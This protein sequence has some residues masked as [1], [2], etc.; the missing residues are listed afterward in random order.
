MIVISWPCLLPLQAVWPGS[1]GA[2]QAFRTGRAYRGLHELFRPVKCLVVLHRGDFWSGKSYQMFTEAASTMVVR[3]VMLEKKI[4]RILRTLTQA[5]LTKH[6]QLQC[7]GSPARYK[8]YFVIVLN[9]NIWVCGCLLLGKFVWLS[10]KLGHYSFT[11][12]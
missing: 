9:L 11:N 1:I 5:Q 4:T 3:R 6:T 7:S 8:C 12:D 10:F 2:A